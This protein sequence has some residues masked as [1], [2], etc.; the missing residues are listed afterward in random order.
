VELRLLQ[1][2]TT[3]RRPQSSRGSAVP[4]MRFRPLQ[5]I[6]TTGATFITRVCLTRLRS[7]SR[8]S[9]PPDGLLP[10]RPCGLVSCR[11]RSWGS[12][13][14]SFSLCR[15][16]SAS[17]RPQPSCRQPTAL[18]TDLQGQDATRARVR[19]TQGHAQLLRRS[20]GR[21]AF[22]VYL[23]GRVRCC[24]LGVEPSSST[25]LSWGSASSGFHANRTWERCFQRSSSHGLPRFALYTGPIRTRILVETARPSESLSVLTRASRLSLRRRPS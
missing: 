23:R 18:H 14:Q 17:R 20:H 3:R 2:M 8:V 21:P 24:A 16:R 5:R 12:P 25:W 9:H 11:W 10:R 1:S 15:S 4:L 13:L 22:R 6:R 7:V 19:G